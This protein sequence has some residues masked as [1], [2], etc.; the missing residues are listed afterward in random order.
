MLVCVMQKRMAWLALLLC[1]A[2]APPTQAYDYLRV[3]D[4]QQWWGSSQGTIES[5][6][7]SV[8]P[9]GLYIEYGLYL[10]FSARG[11]GFGAGNMLEVEF[12]FD[13]PE[14]AVV[15]DS[16]LWVGDDIMQAQIIDQWTAST[17]YEDIVNRRRDPSILYKRGPGQ[18]ELRI[19]PM[20]G[21]E[22]RKVKLTYLVPAQWSS[23]SVSAALPLNLLRT[24]TTPPELTVMAFLPPE[25]K[26]P[27]IVGGAEMP[28]EPKEDPVL[29]SYLRAVVPSSAAYGALAFSLEAPLRDGLYLS[30]Y[31]ENDEHL[32]QLA[33]FPTQTLDAASRRKVA[34]LLDYDASNSSVTARQLLDQV[35]LLLHTRLDADDAFN[36]IISHLNVRR[37]SDTWL[38]ADSAS[39]EQAFAALGDNP[40]AGYSNLPALLGNAID[41][42]QQN[43]AEDGPDGTLLLLSNADQ[44]G[45]YQ[46]ANQLVDDVL[47]AASPPIPVYV[48]DFQDR[49]AEYQYIGGRSYYGNE[50]FYTNLARLTGGHYAHVRDGTLFSELV[51]GVFQS[52]E[53]RITAFDVHT[54]L[55]NGFCYGR[56]GRGGDGLSTTASGAV[57]QMGKCRGSFPFV[58]QTSGVYQGEAFSRTFEVGANHAFAADSL[59]RTAWA[60]RYIQAL[61]TEPQTNALITE[62]IDLSVRERVLSLYTAFLALEPSDTVKACTSCVDETGSGV[63]VEDAELP[64]DTLSIEAYPNPFSDRTTIEIIL[65]RDTDAHETEVA[66]YDLLG[67]AVRR[68]DAEL[69]NAGRNIRLVWDG[70]TDTGE[71]VSNGV[72]LCVVT[73][74]SGRTSLKL[75]RVN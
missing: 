49:N 6:V 31:E 26:T 25:W 42:I 2:A 74:P 16:W 65:A 7:L 11:S 59:T 63:D 55:A 54:S 18:Y 32:Y 12:F 61:E 58:V 46:T 52:V 62:I 57:L 75:V 69:Q 45:S 1:A 68:F 15:H 71:Y 21:D 29:G 72:Y 28:F 3:H 36:L 41:F 4:P 14:G 23:Q 35:R 22:T 38:P 13:L 48:A 9:K 10:T 27:Q 33:F 40:L 51:D 47:Q 30:R 5:A 24:S 19:Y 73:T 70:T 17:I 20:R 34:F 37:A 64:A 8:R 53:G 39:I 44:V 60:G 67:R 56:L 66:I 43:D 50:Y